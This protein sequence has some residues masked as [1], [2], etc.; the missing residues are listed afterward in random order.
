[1]VPE[2]CPKITLRCET[3]MMGMKCRIWAAKIM[4]LV[5][6]KVKTGVH[7]QGK[8]LRRAMQ[9]DGHWPGLGYEVSQMSRMSM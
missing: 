7:Y 9:G 1:M 8:C 6:I 4:L 2:S 3:G 5:R